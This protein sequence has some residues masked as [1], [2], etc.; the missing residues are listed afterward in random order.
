LSNEVNKTWLETGENT[1]P[2]AV[3]DVTSTYVNTAVTIDVLTN[4]SDPDGDALTVTNATDPAN[5]QVVVNAD[6]TITYT[7][8]PDFNGSDSFSYS[9]SDGNGGTDS[10]N[11]YISIYE[12]VGP[13]QTAGSSVTIQTGGGT[14]PVVKCKWEQDT[15]ASLED[16]DPTHIE[17][18]PDV[19]ANAQFLPPLTKGGKKMIRYFAV[20][21]D[22]EDGGNV[23][24]VYADVYHPKDS[25]PPYST[26]DDPRGAYFKYEIPFSSL[27][28]DYTAEEKAAEIDFL[29]DAY[30]AHLIKFQSGYDIDDI[31]YELEKGT[32]SL[33]MGQKEIDYEQPAGDYT[34][35]AYAIDQTSNISEVLVN[36]F[37]YVPVAGVEVD[38]S[39]V[40][41]GSV[42]LGVE[43]MVTGDT[44]WDTPLDAAPSPN[45]ATVRNIGNTWAHVTI[46]QTD[47]GFGKDG[48][49]NWNVMFDARMGSD[50]I[51]KV[52]FAPNTTVT[53]P[54]YL[55]LSS[56]DEIDLSI[57]VIK[58][59]SG[60]TYTGTLTIG[61][62]IEPFTSIPQ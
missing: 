4:D 59:T 17:Y 5:G 57:V 8:D 24:Q 43:K 26:S 36:F 52:S 14:D 46:Y 39:S 25:P 62:E 1:P 56:Q 28:G 41:Y 49:G 61:A 2:V 16:G 9:I 48:N 33:W 13:T 7:P 20:V 11:V 51:N 58:G 47:M 38:F 31:R 3:N 45:P 15:T 54:N 22:A 6:N 12:S 55:Q 23:D 50:D 60:A 34:V 35:N 30:N 19:T 37:N 29:N 21:T 18:S 44:V 32:A 40:N 42:R 53:L 10:A 27:A